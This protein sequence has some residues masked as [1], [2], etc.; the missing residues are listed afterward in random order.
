MRALGVDTGLRG[1]VVEVDDHGHPVRAY[2]LNPGKREE[3]WGTLSP[4]EVRRI[5][6]QMARALLDAEVGAVCYEQISAT[7]GIHA[8]R[9]LFAVE[10]LL[11]H[12][13]AEIGLPLFPVAQSTLRA[14][15]K[16]KCRIQKWRKGQG[17]AQ[18]MEGMREHWP[19]V[20]DALQRAYG[21]HIPEK[22]WPDLVD[23]YWAAIWLQENHTTTNGDTDA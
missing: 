5:R 19:H 3:G 20:L 6:G 2:L 9:Q 4:R 8:T 7:Q 21:D 23:G 12:D 16:R 17:K 14:F 13:A 10:T 15:I 18:V 11:L 1:A 22:R